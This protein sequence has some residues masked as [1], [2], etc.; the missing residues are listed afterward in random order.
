MER[1]PPSSDEQSNTTSTRTAVTSKTAHVRVSG[2]SV[3]IES[4][5]IAVGLRG[6]HRLPHH[7]CKKAYVPASINVNTITVIRTT[8]KSHATG[9]LSN[10]AREAPMLSVSGGSG[11][12]S[13]VFDLSLGIRTESGGSWLRTAVPTPSDSPIFSLSSKGSLGS[14]R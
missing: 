10:R 3:A 11:W 12:R 8:K 5:R 6:L 9:R 1:S 4:S 7:K 13:G 2:Q 14:L